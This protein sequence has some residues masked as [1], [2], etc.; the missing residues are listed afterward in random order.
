MIELLYR[1]LPDVV[2]RQAVLVDNP[3]RSLGF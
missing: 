3:A 1:Y 2:S